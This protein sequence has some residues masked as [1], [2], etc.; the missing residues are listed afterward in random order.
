MTVDDVHLMDSNTYEDKKRSTIRDI[1]RRMS[2]HGRQGHITPLSTRMAEADARN[3]AESDAAKC[4]SGQ[5]P[6]IPISRLTRK[7]Y[8]L[9][10]AALL[11]RPETT[12]PACLQ[13]APPSSHDTSVLRP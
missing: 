2:G 13:T 1:Q 10:K 3:R 9:T 12:C 4:L 7:Q 5:T 8:E 11:R 6:E